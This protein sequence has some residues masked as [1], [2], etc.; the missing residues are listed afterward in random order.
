MFITATKLA[1]VESLRAVLPSGL[2]SQNY[3]APKSVDVEYPVKPELWPALFV[4]FRVGKSEWIGLNGNYGEVF[5]VN[6][7]ERLIRRGYFTG[8]VDLTVLSISSHERDRIWDGITEIFLMGR[9]HPVLKA[10]TDTL[11]GHDVIDMT[12]KDS[13]VKQVG[14]SVGVGTPWGT[15]DVTYEATVRFDVQ[16]EFYADM[17]TQELV[18]VTDIKFD[19]TIE[20]QPFTGIGAD[21]TGWQT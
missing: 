9:Q 6:G 10:F 8:F 18:P 15:D 2:E 14:D 19:F 21:P 7:E 4:Q 12:V 3:I 13:E 1:L 17:E 11:H 20:G 16:G 5:E